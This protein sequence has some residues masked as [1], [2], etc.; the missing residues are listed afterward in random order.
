[1]SN[2]TIALVGLSGVG[3]STLI[4]KVCNDIPFQT[5]SASQL[6]KNQKET[7]T[8]HDELRFQDINDNQRLLVDGFKKNID[9]KQKLILLDGHTVIETANGLIDI[10][11]NVF[12][13]IGIN[14]FIFLA[15]EADSILQRR[16]KDK[17]RKRSIV[18]TEQINT[19]QT[20][21]QIVTARISLEL[22]V[23][24]TIITSDDISTFKSILLNASTFI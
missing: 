23:P 1:M 15:E 18:T 7:Y 14:Q 5:L 20:H 13:E 8:Q 2:I 10:S 6:I 3:K 4:K 21:T 17:S 9:P 24:L 19:Y 16:S 22:R 11:A 12:R